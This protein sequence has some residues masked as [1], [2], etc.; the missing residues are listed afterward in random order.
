[1]KFKPFKSIGHSISHAFKD[2]GKFVEKNVGNVYHDVK[3]A[4]GYTGKHLI[5]DVDKI[6]STLSNPLIYIGL[7]AVVLIILLKK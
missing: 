6:S 4:V 7:G 2:T 3:G 1:M 5:G